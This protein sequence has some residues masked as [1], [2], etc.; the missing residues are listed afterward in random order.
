MRN[1][2]N[3]GTESMMGAVVD[4]AFGKLVVKDGKYTVQF[5][6]R[7]MSVMGATADLNGMKYYPGGYV[8]NNAGMLQG[9]MVDCETE[10][11]YTG[12]DGAERPLT[13]L[14]PLSDAAISDGYICMYAMSTYMNAQVVLGLDWAEF[15][16]K[17][18]GH[19]VVTKDALNDQLAEAAKVASS[20]SLEYTLLKKAI[21]AA[22]V[23][24]ADENATQ[25]DVD[26]QTKALADALKVYN[27]QPLTE[28]ADGQ[29]WRMGDQLLTKDGSESR[30][31]GYFAE[32]VQVKRT[33][34]SYQVSITTKAAYDSYITGVTCGDAAAISVDNGNGTH[35]Y[36]FATDSLTRAMQLAFGINVGGNATTVSAC[37][38]LDTG[39]AT[40]VDSGQAEVS[41]VA[42]QTKVDAVAS[43]NESDYT[44]QSWK[45][46]Q[47][48][49]AAADA[50]LANNDATQA[51]V[52]A[53]TA[54]LAAAYQGLAKANAS[55]DNG[56]TTGDNGANGT[57]NSGNANGGSN[58]NASGA[59]A[60][61][62]G[63]LSQTGDMAPVAPIVGGGLIAVLGAIIS[64]AALRLCKRN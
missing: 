49:I 58:G 60:S 4:K 31:N 22:Q 26:A 15:D 27:G 57:A 29:T 10:G 61:A 24:A 28:V 1:A 39:D 11:T 48:A 55:S 46:L 38:V 19:E 13:Y 47:S 36:T 7:S 54:T 41:K 30:A 6:V 42:P 5:N 56:G 32:G 44:A 50:V 12:A 25:A 3:V 2:T 40:L 62:S 63:T 8:E 45:A 18:D 34:D 52:D 23:V 20:D 59:A 14:V 21:D 64:A 37:L 16:A 33:G 9:N 51:G 53:A 17:Y 35:T 43:L